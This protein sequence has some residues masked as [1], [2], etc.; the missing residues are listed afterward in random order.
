MQLYQKV[1]VEDALKEAQEILI[2]CG[3][4]SFCVDQLLRR[5]QA[6]QDILDK[7]PLPNKGMVDSVIEAVI[8]PEHRL[9]DT[10]GIPSQTMTTLAGQANL[11]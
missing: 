6:A 7:T 4:V 1:S 2:Q 5:H 9:F 8:A 11:E 10:L 3:A